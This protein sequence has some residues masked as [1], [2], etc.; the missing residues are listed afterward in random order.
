MKIIQILIIWVIILFTVSGGACKKPP[1]EVSGTDTLV[2]IQGLDTPWEILW[3]PDNFI[4]LT[5]RSGKVSRVNPTTGEKNEILILS[6]VHEQS[7]SG[8]MGLV[9]HPDFD[10][11]P[12][13]YLAYN[14]L[15]N[16]LINLRITRF[17]YS[18]GTLI[19]PLTLLDGIDGNP[20]HNGC[21]LM[22]GQDSKLYITTGDAQNAS[23]GQD[24]ESLSGKILRMNLD[25]SVP[26]DNPISGSLLWSWG[27]RNPQGLVQSPSGIIYSSEHGPINDDEVNLIEKGRNYGWPN[28][29]GFCD[30]S[31]EQNFCTENNIV[32]PLA[33]WTPTL[34]VAGIDLY[35][36]SE[37]PAWENSLL[38]ANLKASSITVM[39]LSDDGKSILS[40]TD[41]FENMWGR[42]RDICISPEG[43]VFIATSNRDGRGTVRAG[44][45]KI[46]EIR[47]IMTTVKI[48]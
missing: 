26:S 23:L 33:A 30:K 38:M 12:Y 15:D 32:Q 1:R 7:E 4:W 40:Q 21:R 41:Y 9:L 46:I 14:Y 39:K 43:R 2:L 20:N 29:E 16:S 35:T 10:T 24:L 42:L 25:G 22:I 17:T 37:I 13:V 8:M 11:D 47:P 34:A 27:H 48:R 44:D 6:G 3:G 36:G 31:Y 28:I 19:S 45:D 18:Q 5:E